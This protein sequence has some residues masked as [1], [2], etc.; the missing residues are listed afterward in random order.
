MRRP[1]EVLVGV[2]VEEQPDRQPQA[3][4]DGDQVFS[5]RGRGGGAR[6]RGPGSLHIQIHKYMK[7]CNLGVGNVTS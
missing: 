6:G 7:P 1:V 4:G 5:S 3:A 2:A